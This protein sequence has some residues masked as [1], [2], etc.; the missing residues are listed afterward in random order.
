MRTIHVVLRLLT[1][2]LVFVTGVQIS[3]AAQKSYPMVCRGGGD[4]EARFSHVKSRGGFHNT[5]LSVTF[6]KSPAAASSTE[7]A[8]GHCA[9][10]DRPITGEE[11][12]SFAYS[13]GSSMDFSFVFDADGWTLRDTE[14]E[15]L[16]HILD[17]MRRGEVFYLRCHREGG[18]L[19]VDRVGP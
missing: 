11:P 18:Y 3:L 1:V 8:P 12:S 14:D 9:W 6:K 7:P 15:G 16:K 13:P 17:K 19:R 10:L 2:C 5:S 4:M